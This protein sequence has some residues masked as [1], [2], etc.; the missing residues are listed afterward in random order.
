M[1]YNIVVSSDFARDL[2][3][4]A[5]RYPSIKRDIATQET[6]TDRELAARLKSLGLKK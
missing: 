5:K 6:V 4:L 1:K 2:K 3:H